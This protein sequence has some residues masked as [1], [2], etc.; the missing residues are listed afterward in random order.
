MGYYTRHK[1][2]ITPFTK[3]AFDD[4]IETSGYDAYHMDG[5]ECKWYD[6][7]SD[8]IIVS[9]RHPEQLFC[10]HGCGEESGDIWRSHFKNGKSH[11]DQVVLEFKPFDESSLK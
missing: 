5:E 11:K 9:K 2:T 6:L 7:E 10:I 8:M 1:L 4:V 3:E